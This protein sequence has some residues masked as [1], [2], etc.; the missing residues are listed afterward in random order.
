MSQQLV[1]QYNK[2]DIEMIL[3]GRILVVDDE[4]YLRWPCSTACLMRAMK[5]WWPRMVE[6][7]WRW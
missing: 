4:Q 3:M 2:Y 7:H 1:K 6:R 5:C